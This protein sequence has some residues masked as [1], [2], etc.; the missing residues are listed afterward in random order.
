MTFEEW[1]ETEGYDQAAMIT[2][3]WLVSERRSKMIWQEATEAERELQPCGHPVQAIQSGTDDLVPGGEVTNWCGWC[4]D[5]ERL[6][7]EWWADFNEMTLRI[8]DTEIENARLRKALAGLFGQVGTSPDA[9][10]E[11]WCQWC[12][13]KGETGLEQDIVHE[14]GCPFAALS[15]PTADWLAQHDAQVRQE[16]RERAARLVEETSIVTES[17]GLYGTTI[18]HVRI[19]VHEIAAAIREQG[20]EHHVES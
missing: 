1:W 16:E 3:P 19:D 11:L 9:Y 15:T 4:A 13:S 6:R 7:E 10:G 12:Q 20:E 17:E 14:P 2:P 5:I 8:T 18:K